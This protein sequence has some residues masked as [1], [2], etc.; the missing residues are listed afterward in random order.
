MKKTILLTIFI[1]ILVNISIAGIVRVPRN[2]KK[3]ELHDIQNL[4]GTNFVLCYKTSQRWF[5]GGITFTDDGYALREIG[6]D[7]QYVPL[8]E[9][10]IKELQSRGELP[11]PLPKYTISTERYLKGYSFWIGLVVLIIISK[12]Y[13]AVKPT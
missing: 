10:I 1:G 13:Q 3:Q 7:D 8:D 9:Q 12:I 4:E 2:L 6:N 5:I 11:N